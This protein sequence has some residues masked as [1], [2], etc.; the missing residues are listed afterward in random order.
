M[1]SFLEETELDY[2]HDLSLLKLW[3][4]PT[5]VNQSLHPLQKFEDTPIFFP[6]HLGQSTVA[7]DT[8]YGY[9]N[10]TTAFYSEAK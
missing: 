9:K 6:S 5:L 4:L 10:N 8:V 1:F 3:I 2:N 7:P